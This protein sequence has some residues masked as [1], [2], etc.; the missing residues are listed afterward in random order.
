MK[1]ITKKLLP[2]YVV[3]QPKGGVGKTTVAQQV[4]PAVLKINPENANK[5]IAIFEFDDNNNKR[6]N[7]S[8]E[9]NIINTTFKINNADN[10]LEGLSLDILSNDDLIVIIDC[11]GSND[12]HRVL[13]ALNT[14]DFYDCHYCIPTLAG[15]DP[16]SLIALAKKIKDLDPNGEMNYFLNKCRELNGNTI[17]EDFWQIYGDKELEELTDNTQ[18]LAIDNVYYVPEIN[19]FS[20]LA[21]FQKSIYDIV[22]ETNSFELKDIREVK[23]EWS[24]MGE[25]GRKLNSMYK[26]GKTCRTGFNNFLKYNKLE[27]GI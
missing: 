5:K 7:Y 4:L 20:K 22:Q 27:K 3:A 8:E 24:K 26:F 21:M 16:Q 23:L 11:G 9:S 19:I 12:T 10:I 6:F 13:E 15:D 18:I 14:N 25:E 2:I 17:T 1:K